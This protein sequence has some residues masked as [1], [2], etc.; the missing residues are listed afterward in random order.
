[1]LEVNIQRELRV[2]KVLTKERKRRSID[3]LSR[4]EARVV[5]RGALEP[6]HHQRQVINPVGTSQPCWREDFKDQ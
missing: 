4:R 3:G 6:K 5:L 1:M 2:P